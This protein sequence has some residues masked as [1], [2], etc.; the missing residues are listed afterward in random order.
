VRCVA[1]QPQPQGHAAS[2][3]SARRASASINSLK[4]SL[5]STAVAGTV[6]DE[7]AL[8]AGHSSQ[9]WSPEEEVPTS[10]CLPPW[11]V[12]VRVAAELLGAL[13]NR[14]PEH[15]GLRSGRL[16][17]HRGAYPHRAAPV[18]E[19]VWLRAGP[20]SL[21]PLPTCSA[22]PL[23]QVTVRRLQRRQ[24]RRPTR[25]RSP[26]S[27]VAK[28][29]RRAA[30]IARDPLRRG[31]V[32]RRVTKGVTEREKPLASQGRHGSCCCSVG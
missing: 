15:T 1:A 32:E 9:V 19:Y 23:R 24:P 28:T 25:E 31:L 22:K 26:R 13:L 21:R 2:F 20:L 6:R 4:S 11:S 10:P 29:T 3:S 7:D 18:R 8:G 27:R 30:S 16:G 17:P 5:A 14:T 12:P